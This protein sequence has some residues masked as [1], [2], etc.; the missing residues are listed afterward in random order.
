MRSWHDFHLTGFAVDGARE[1]LTFHLEWPYE[2]ESPVRRGRVLFSGVECYYLEHDVGTNIVYGIEEVPLQEHLTEWVD[3]FE[4]EC[5]WGWPRFWRPK[6][7]PR[8]SVEIELSEA[9]ERLTLRGV[10]CFE[11][12]S[13][14]GL[15]GWILAAHVEESL[16]A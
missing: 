8:R 6:P 14:L 13:S 3:R 7:Y 16:E 15:S 4:T 12:T 9:I 5:K 11:L 2:T 1:T 10:K